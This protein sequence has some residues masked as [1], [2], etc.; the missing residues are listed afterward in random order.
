MKDIKGLRAK[1]PPTIWPDVDAIINHVTKNIQGGDVVCVFSNGG[2]GGI[3]GKLLERLGREMIL[4]A[5]ASRWRVC[6]APTC[7]RL[8]VSSA[9][10]T[11]ENPKPCQ[12][13]QRAG[14]SPK[15]AGADVM[16]R[17]ENRDSVFWN[18]PALWRFKR[19]AWNRRLIKIRH[20]FPQYLHSFFR[21][22][23]FPTVG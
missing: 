14:G 9:Q 18:A 10:I 11:N 2:F 8:C 12:K 21:F 15:N 1:A 13:R 19:I 16:E 17:S 4:G 20:H 7:S 5:A 22:S 6:G 3:H 23:H